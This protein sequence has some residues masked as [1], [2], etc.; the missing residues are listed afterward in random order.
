MLHP[1]A[2]PKPLGLAIWCPI[3]VRRVGTGAKSVDGVLPLRTLN[4]R[5][6]TDSVESFS[7][8]NPETM[9]G[10][11]HLTLHG[12]VGPFGVNSSM[13]LNLIHT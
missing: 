5:G 7:E 4:G 12:Y 1:N 8:K 6:I 11:K 13:L 9:G 10:T 3:E 2:V